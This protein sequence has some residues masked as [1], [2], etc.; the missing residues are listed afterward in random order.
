M[1]P[2]PASVEERERSDLNSSLNLSRLSTNTDA[3]TVLN[4]STFNESMSLDMSFA[5]S[6]EAPRRSRGSPVAESLT[7]ADLPLSPHQEIAS[8]PAITVDLSSVISSGPT[9]LTMYPV[10]PE[11]AN[12]PSG[13][14]VTYSA[15]S[16]STSSK[17]LFDDHGSPLQVRDVPSP[18]RPVAPS[19]LKEARMRTPIKSALKRRNAP[20]TD[21]I[22]LSTGKMGLVTG[23]LAFTRDPIA[24]GSAVL[25]AIR[26]V[27]T[28]VANQINKEKKRV[29]VF[30]CYVVRFLRIVISCL[31]GIYPGQNN[32]HKQNS[33]TIYYCLFQITWQASEMALIPAVGDDRYALVDL[34]SDQEYMSS[35]QDQNAAAEAEDEELPVFSMRNAFDEM[36]PGSNESETANEA[37]E[38]PTDAIKE[39]IG[40][41]ASEEAKQDPSPSAA[42]QTPE[43]KERSASAVHTPKTAEKF[44]TS[45]LAAVAER[46]KALTAF[47]PQSSTSASEDQRD[48]ESTPAPSSTGKD[49]KTPREQTPVSGRLGT[50]NVGTP[51]NAY[52]SDL[53]VH[54]TVAADA[55]ILSSVTDAFSPVPSRAPASILPTNPLL[56]P[57]VSRLPFS[58]SK[59]QH[60]DAF[61]ADVSIENVSMDV[62]NVQT[63]MNTSLDCTI[64]QVQP[65]TPPNTP[66]A[67]LPKVI[68]D[69][70]LETVARKKA[71]VRETAE[72]KAMNPE[73]APSGTSSAPSALAK[74]IINV[75]TYEKQPFAV[76]VASRKIM[77]EVHGFIQHMKKEI[78]N[79]TA[80]VDTNASVN[81]VAASVTSPAIPRTTSTSAQSPAGKPTT[82]SAS[83]LPAAA[84]AIIRSREASA[85]AKAT[86]SAAASA[87]TTASTTQ[88]EGKALELV[89]TDQIKTA[90]LLAT[91][92]RSLT[93]PARRPVTPTS[94]KKSVS[95]TS[96]GARKNRRLSLVQL[97]IQQQERMEEDKIEGEA[98][99]DAKTPGT[100][101]RVATPAKSPHVVAIRVAD[102]ASTAAAAVVCST[103]SSPVPVASTAPSS[104]AN[105]PAPVESSKTPTQQTP[106]Q[107]PHRV[108]ISIP[109]HVPLGCEQ[110]LLVL[111]PILSP[112]TPRTPLTGNKM[113]ISTSNTPAAAEGNIASNAEEATAENVENAPESN[114]R[115]Q[116]H[117]IF[118][119]DGRHL[120][121]I[122]DILD[123]LGQ[124]VAPLSTISLLSPSLKSSATTGNAPQVDVEA[125]AL[126]SN[127]DAEAQGSLDSKELA[128]L[129]AFTNA[130]SPAE[131]TALQE[132]Q[133]IVFDESGQAHSVLP[134]LSTI[135][136]TLKQ[137]HVETLFVSNADGTN[138][139]S[140]SDD[141]QKDVSIETATGRQDDDR[142]FASVA[143]K[144]TPSNAKT[145][146]KEEY[147]P[148]DWNREIS[149][150]SSFVASRQSMSSPSAIRAV[151][152]T[153]DNSAQ[154]PSKNTPVST[155]EGGIGDGEIAFNTKKG[156]HLVIQSNTPGS[157]VASPIT[158]LEDITKSEETS[159][160]AAHPVFDVF[161][162]VDAAAETDV[163]GEDISEE[164]I[165]NSDKEEKGTKEEA[166][167]VAVV[168]G[169][170]D[171]PAV[172]ASNPSKSSRQSTPTTSSK[173]VLTSV[174]S[175]PS[176]GLKSTPTLTA[177]ASIR[178][179]SIGQ[180]RNPSQKDSPAPIAN[181]SAVF[182]ENDEALTEAAASST[183]T[184]PKTPKT[185]AK[186]V[187]TPATASRKR[188]RN[189][190]DIS[191]ANILPADQESNEY[192]STVGMYKR[193]ALQTPHKASEFLRTP[194]P[195]RQSMRL[196]SMKKEATSK[197]VAVTPATAKST[198]KRGREDD[199]AAPAEEMEGKMLQFPP[200]TPS[201]TPSKAASKT[202]AE[203]TSKTPAKEAPKTPAVLRS[204]TKRAVSAMKV[205]EL[206]DYLGQAGLKVSG[207]KADLTSRLLS[208]MDEAAEEDSETPK[209]PKAPKTPAKKAAPTPG[210]SKRAATPA[211]GEDN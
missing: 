161:Y 59:P 25:S 79:S 45:F 182:T 134:S 95:R 142:D 68:F 61:A 96:T 166:D 145:Q 171:G 205:A 186:A 98:G 168:G 210:R 78:Q 149:A 89:V 30:A 184:T 43:S 38:E 70:L 109:D 44:H 46:V 115:V 99:D 113:S 187:A 150:H 175:L 160:A 62:D 74:D 107:A 29:C 156:T 124:A 92:P 83:P 20:E 51:A 32:V 189:F 132:A 209:A 82:T 100:V 90:E 49:S 84:L 3:E 12:T 141:A 120:E 136:W 121:V 31:L 5:V 50:P 123:A 48:K 198:R 11:T 137:G 206:K 9:Q 197:T 72:E 191:A 106:I 71:I 63:P 127:E 22:P 93:T 159:I 135:S 183:K 158:S 65:G 133:H 138:S 155:E 125:G 53:I 144:T 178:R 185:P 69:E 88:I 192:A 104:N 23:I 177:A 54:V 118:D 208:A 40:P 64:S 76:S 140:T 111:S 110:G 14:S 101:S 163:E 108:V 97:L 152:S 170:N 203:T 77:Q 36:E 147:V 112:K 122:G 42:P 143:M 169:S 116:T 105:T 80:S 2:L 114:Y 131:R 1:P 202:L 139:P 75:A 85:A 6:P 39:D 151:Q 7:G 91:P 34:Q 195:T 8:S 154:R 164:E 194:V 24:V 188:T 66:A 174:S 52:T 102:L 17:C 60:H 21:G 190:T 129:T 199:E 33:H 37:S 16:S 211:G 162:G 157:T 176:S 58:A 4:T 94:G 26:G 67:A 81:S 148:W 117:V 35:Q 73:L 13:A 41:S 119:S 196:V 15:A 103:L 146:E 193:R 87:A 19:A 47:T 200:K 201:K 86:I 56:S 57:L 10:T 126:S 128:G 167:A 179:H 172:V 18:L 27:P 153:P 173:P 130:L 204:L 181:L 207:L 28:P 180:E 55:G 165:S